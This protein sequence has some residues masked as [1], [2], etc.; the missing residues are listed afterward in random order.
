MGPAPTATTA[1]G[2]PLLIHQES[3]SMFERHADSGLLTR[4]RDLGVG[5]IAFSPLGQGS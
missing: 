4:L 2:T 1:L 3:Y 5:S